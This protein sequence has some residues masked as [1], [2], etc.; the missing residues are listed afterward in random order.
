MKPQGASIL[1]MDHLL[2]AGFAAQHT[3]WQQASDPD[4]NK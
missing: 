1:G 4:F 3:G 2:A